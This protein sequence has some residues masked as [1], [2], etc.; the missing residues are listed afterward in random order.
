[1]GVTTTPDTVR[2][3]VDDGIR[4]YF[5]ERRRKIRPFV[6]QNFSLRGSVELHRAAIGWD[7][8]KAP[9]NLML[10]APQAGLLAV[11]GI[12]HKL[13]AP[14]TAARLGKTRLVMQ[15]AVGR[16]LSWRLHTELLE[17]PFE[18]NGRIA[19]RDALA[20]TILADPRVA[21]TMTAAITAI[22][23]H[24]NDPALRL[25]LEAA[26][27]EYGR[28]RAAA[29]EITTALLSL[30]AG[31]MI[32]R[33]L[34]PGALTLGPSMAAAIAQQTAIMSFPLGGTLGTLWYSLFPVA[35][36]ALLVASLTTGLLAAS[37]VV[38]AFAG[39]IADPV[40]RKL[41]LHEARLR[42]MIGSVERQLQDPAAA[43]FVVHDHYVARLAD[44][45]DVAG[46]VTRAI[47]LT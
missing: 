25:R 39:I 29:T 5:A 7:I 12:A 2:Q 20:E 4:R 28:T 38:S 23:A 11:S 14:E 43:G 26:L 40:Q 3:I 35:P 10:A 42:R 34:T 31:A 17:L 33:Q 6:D 9:L 19:T 13:G 8:A 37:T 44:L 30:A 36:S 1:M 46:A 27:I 47:T 24:G 18:S 22:S 21:G 32:L 15:T 45:F 16:E 41:G